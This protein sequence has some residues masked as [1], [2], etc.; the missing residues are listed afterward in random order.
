[1][2]IKIKPAE[3]GRRVLKTQEAQMGLFTTKGQRYATKREGSRHA[4]SF[5]CPDDCPNSEIMTSLYP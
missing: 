1:M 2:S 3:N 5:E 4:H